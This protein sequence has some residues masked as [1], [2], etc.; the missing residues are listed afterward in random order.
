MSLPSFG[1]W[2]HYVLPISFPGQP[3]H[4]HRLMQVLE[5]DEQS[6]LVSGNLMLQ[7]EDDVLG[8]L[9]PGTCPCG[10]RVIGCTEDTT[11]LEVG[12]FHAANLSHE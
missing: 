11:T 6:Q 5:I 3:G 12:T 2:V 9:P 4:P 1:E 8:L 10:K 7:A